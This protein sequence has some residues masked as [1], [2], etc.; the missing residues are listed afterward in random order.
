MTSL[1][2]EN[3]WRL[4]KLE[5]KDPKK[6]PKMTLVKEEPVKVTKENAKETKEEPVKVTKEN[7]KETKEEPV[8]VTKENPKENKRRTSQSNKRKC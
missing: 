2:S 7:A 3:R 4:A 5:G 6:Q 8:K 1:N